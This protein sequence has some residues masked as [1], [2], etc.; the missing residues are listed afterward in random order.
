M[1]EIIRFIFSGL[2]LAIIQT[3]IFKEI[4]LAWWIKPMPY[5]YFFF[6]L[7]IS[8]N[9]FGVLVGSFFFGL[10]LDFWGGSMGMHSA[11]CVSIA[12]IKN[13]IDRYFVNENSLQLQGFQTVNEQYKGWKWYYLYCLSIILAHHLIFFSFDYFRWSALFTIISISIVSAV[14]TIFFMQIFR[15]LV[16]KK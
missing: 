7:P 10:T 8:A 6:L 1:I 14:S 4:N 12:F 13:A 5:V 9:R 11:A 2:I 3:M 16:G 15:Y